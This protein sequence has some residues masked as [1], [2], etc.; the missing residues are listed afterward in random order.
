VPLTL[1]NGS[2]VGTL[3]IADHRPRLL[4]D[5]ELDALRQLADQVVTALSPE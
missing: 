2:R 3:C 5:T 4:D 1:E